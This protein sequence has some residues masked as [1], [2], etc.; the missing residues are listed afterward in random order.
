MTNLITKDYGESIRFLGD[1][2]I[3]GIGIAGGVF[4]VSIVINAVLQIKKTLLDKKEA[5]QK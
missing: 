3:I 4:G 1:T 5:G 2:V